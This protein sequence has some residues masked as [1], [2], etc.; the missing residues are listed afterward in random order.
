M[1]ELWGTLSFCG[2]TD[3]LALFLNR[4]SSTVFICG[5]ESCF[6]NK[7]IILSSFE[8]ITIWLNAA[9][10]CKKATGISTL[11]SRCSNKS[12]FCIDDLVCTLMNHSIK[13][14]FESNLFAFGMNSLLNTP[15]Q[16]FISCN[17][18]SAFFHSLR[19]RASCWERV[20]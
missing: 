1:V 10:S 16:W 13:T 19:V 12:A 3:S 20:V 17:F 8:I 4:F 9:C 7:A 18:L 2:C 15:I 6:N 5:I 11:P 14:A